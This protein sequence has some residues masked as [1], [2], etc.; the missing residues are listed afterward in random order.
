MPKIEE[1]LAE[2]REKYPYIQTKGVQ[3]DFSTMTTLSEYNELA[4]KLDDLDIGILCLNAG[5]S[6]LAT[7]ENISD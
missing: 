2:I 1:K 3:A 5:V 6:R 7:I 4:R